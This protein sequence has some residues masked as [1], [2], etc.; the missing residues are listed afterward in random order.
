M[1]SYKVVAAFF[2]GAIMI[3]SI[4]AVYAE[5]KSQTLD[6]CENPDLMLDSEEATLILSEIMSWD[7]IYG[8]NYIS[9][10]NACASKL[11]RG[12]VA[13]IDGVGF[14]RD[15]AVVASALEQQRNES[16]R[17]KR[18]QED[19]ATWNK[20]R[21]MFSTGEY[22]SQVHMQL[23]EI[24]SKIRE[25]NEVIEEYERKTASLREAVIRETYEACSNIYKATPGRALL[26]PTCNQIFLKSGLPTSQSG[27]I[28]LIEKLMAERKVSALLRKR[29]IMET[30]GLLLE[31]SLEMVRIE[32]L[33]TA[34]YTC[35]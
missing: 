14:T 3:S 11:G 10:A 32:N 18:D 1:T 33:S 13:Y 9:R 6:A 26:N 23:C 5:S 29:D 22:K 21:E 28:I 2:L 30:T 34:E 12:P 25:G 31:D 8:P 16:A 15:E 17:R 19:L 7:V 24:I 27:E 4:K 20:R 35:N